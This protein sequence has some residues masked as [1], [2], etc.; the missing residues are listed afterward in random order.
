V[1]TVTVAD[2]TMTMLGAMPF[3]VTEGAV[4]TVATASVATEGAGADQGAGGGR[5]L[6]DEV[7]RS[8]ERGARRRADSFERIAEVVAAGE[9]VRQARGGVR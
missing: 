8:R 3:H 5:L 2:W 7:R 9:R 6:A 1:G 4:G